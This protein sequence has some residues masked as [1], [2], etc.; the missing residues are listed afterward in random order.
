MLFIHCTHGLGK[1]LLRRQ[2][3]EGLGFELWIMDFELWIDLKD[4]YSL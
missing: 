1:G 4:F 3:S 2:E